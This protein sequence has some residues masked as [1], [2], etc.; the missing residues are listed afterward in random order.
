MVR[1]GKVRGDGREGTRGR[2]G[3]YAN[4]SDQI[5]SHKDY[6]KKDKGSRKKSS[7]LSGPA[8]K[9]FS[10]PLGLVAIG[11][12]FLTLKRVIFL[13]AHPFSPSLWPA[14]KKRFF[15][16]ASLRGTANILIR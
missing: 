13:V 4:C 1:E 8:T 2:K 15:L 16:A 9:A 6:I 11:T 14:T 3:R 7:F 10:L 5:E 12:I